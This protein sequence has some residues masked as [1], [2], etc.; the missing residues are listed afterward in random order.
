MSAEEA[1]TSHASSG[2]E[3]GASSSSTAESSKTNNLMRIQQRKQQ[4][5]NWPR[6]K[7]I[8][9]LAIYSHCQADD[10]KC[11][12]WKTPQPKSPQNKD[13]SVQQ[14]ANFQDPCR[15]CK[16]TLQFHVKHLEPL[17]DSVLNRLLGMVVDV[18]NIFMSMNKELDSD[19]KRVYFYLFKLLRKN[20][21]T[22]QKPIIEGPLGQ[23]PFEKPSMA[24]GVTNFVLYKFGNLPAN[25]WQTN[26]D[27]AKMFLH[28]LNHWNF[29]SPTSHLSN[30]N[31]DE[32]STYKI[33]YTRWLVFCHVPAF[34]DSLPHYETTEVFGR[35]FLKA[36]FQTVC[37]QLMEKCNNER[38]R[39]PPDKRVLVL[40]HF[41]RFLAM[42]EE[43]INNTAS[44]IW[45]AE[46][47]PVAP[48]Y[49][50]AQVDNAEKVAATKSE[51]FEKLNPTAK[52]GF[53]TITINSGTGRRR[54]S[55]SSEQIDAKKKK[56]AD[57]PEKI[58]TEVLATINNPVSTGAEVAVFPENAPRDEAAKLE[59]QK[60][61]ISFVVVG[62]S[63]TR[64]VSK[65][66]ITWLIGLQN[67]FSHQ[68]PRMPKEYISRLVF[69]P[70]HKT[71][72]LLKD[73][74]AIGGICFRMFV[75]Q[76]FTE[77]VFCAVTSNEQVKG[78][79]T[80]LMNHLKDY[81]IRLNVL[82]FLTFADEFAIGYFKK[83]GFS[84]EIKMPK[85]QYNGFIKDYEGATLMHCH[86]NPRIVYTEFTSVIRKQK[87][88]LKKLVEQRQ[89]EFQKVMPGLN[90]FKDGVHSIPIE[91]I[92][93]I[94]ATG[95]L[96]S[97]KNKI[98]AQADNI[99]PEVLV[100]QLR[101]ILGQL[102]THHAAWPFLKPVDINDVPD[103][104]DHIKYPMDLKTI[105]NRLKT[106]YYVNKRLFIADMNRI[107]TNC[108]LYNSPE[109]EY[110]K[111]ANLL[112]KFFQSRMREVGL[113][114]K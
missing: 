60:G 109:T 89:A 63:I 2:N 27:L 110:F 45:D 56:I 52:S 94:Q 91:S 37:R 1:N 92:P 90:C 55:E 48:L 12:G 80:H 43:E 69:D 72:A 11:N 38:D 83:Q 47:K 61:V 93:G 70:K 75:T 108:R 65:Q 71:L 99:D 78:Y 33:N 17:G 4:V 97:L 77:I 36:V 105:E 29:E 62:N 19:T 41:P 88:I 106:S 104:Y 46:Y 30:L 68:L 95:C 79:G 53:T 86:L 51:E 31:C 21:L 74:R 44:P 113:M 35:T 98:K 23:P 26:Y 32:L 100:I 34:C 87:E 28:C 76:G 20:I 84:K 64:P 58:V 13:E 114:E 24:R 81:H 14:L 39:M 66:T 112:E 8:L 67:V 101:T 22:N 111:C 73:G 85:A 16:H 49:L 9:K 59:E 103:Y 7:K 10:C 102:K 107:F 18:E 40:T 25:E 57:V 54:I 3:E 96:P 5:Y 42:L 50:A 82:H 15:H 6:N